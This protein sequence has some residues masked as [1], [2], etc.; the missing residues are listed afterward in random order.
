MK[1]TMIFTLTICLPLIFSA[2]IALAADLPAKDVKILKEAGIPLYKGAE[3][4]NGGLGGEIGARFASSAPVEDVRAFY[5]GKFPAW[6]LNAEYGSW[7]LYDGKPGGG[8]AAY[9]GKQQVSVKENKNLPSWFGVAKNMTTEIMIVV[10][11]K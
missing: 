1:R 6:A 9:M 10:P 8:P 3:F 11:P 7:I 2:G 5:K 4:L